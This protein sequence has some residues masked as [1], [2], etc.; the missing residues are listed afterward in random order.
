MYL[1]CMQLIKSCEKQIQEKQKQKQKTYN[2]LYKW[3][4]TIRGS[5]YRMVYGSPESVLKSRHIL[6]FPWVEWGEGG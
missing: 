1:V 4:E 6:G 2:K 3:R 5:E